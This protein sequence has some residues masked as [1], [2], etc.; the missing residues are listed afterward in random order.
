MKSLLALLLLLACF[1]ASAQQAA[2][3]EFTDQLVKYDLSELWV[4]DSIEIEGGSEKVE[5]SEPLGYI[6]DDF[7]RFQIHFIS[8]NKSPDNPLEYWVVGKTRVKDYICSFEGSLF[9]YYAETDVDTELVGLDITLGVLIG[10]YFFSENPKQKGSGTLKGSFR[11]HFYIDVE[12]ELKYDAIM[13]VADGFY[14]NQFEGKW[15]SYRTGESKKCNWGDY[16][17]PDS[18]DLDWGVC[19]FAPSEH[20]VQNG[21]ANYNLAWGFDPS[22]PEVIEAQEKENE[23]WWLGK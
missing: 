22:K 20:Y 9:I 14:N 11:S 19:E 1:L 3:Q 16:R 4:S 17:I 18:K 7:Q 5:R 12:G 21:W 6:G 23:Q 8:V 2:N 15:T 13:F 10:E